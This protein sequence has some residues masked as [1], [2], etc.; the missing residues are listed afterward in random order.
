MLGVG[1]TV[2]IAGLVKQ[3]G[4]P[5]V[6][7]LERMGLN[8]CWQRARSGLHRQRHRAIA[9]LQALVREQ[10]GQAPDA[11]VLDELTRLL[12]LGKRG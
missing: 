2:I 1:F 10:I 7:T 12:L 11:T 3:V 5:R 6:S 8:V 9:H 4:G